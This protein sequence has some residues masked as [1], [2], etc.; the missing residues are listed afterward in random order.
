MH[1][2]LPPD[3]PGAF[4]YAHDVR[5]EE[6]DA[7]GRA[8]NVAYVTWMLAAATAHSAALGW[9]P[10]AYLARGAGW[11][12]RSH[13]IEYLGAAFAGDRVVVRT[14]VA[15]M[16]GASSIRRYE[17]LRAAGEASRIATA[18]TLWAFVD[19]RTGRPTRIPRE[20]AEA[21]PVLDR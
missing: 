2:H 10:E 12:V 9:P 1:P 20:I 15:T 19:Y 14:W 13:A 11:V 16:D 21:F 3:M 18:E 5:S 8:S 17:M 7:L 4:E 6:I